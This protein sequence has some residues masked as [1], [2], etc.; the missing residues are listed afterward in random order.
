LPGSG[1]VARAESTGA[2]WEGDLVIIGPKK[3][4]LNDDS[5]ID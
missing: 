4:R 5:I 3:F 1:T 2:L